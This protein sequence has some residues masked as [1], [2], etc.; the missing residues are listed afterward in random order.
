M[1]P[2]ILQNP[3]SYETRAIRS[4]ILMLDGVAVFSSTL[5]SLSAFRVDLAWG[6]M[7]VGSVEFVRQAMAIAGLREPANMSYPM[8]AMPYLRRQVRETVAGAVSERAFVKPVRTKKFTGFV[9]DPASDP[10]SL[11]EH[12]REQHAAFASAHADEPVWTSE[13]VSFV[14]E[15][16][17]YVSRGR[18]MGS[19]RY[20]PHDTPDAPAPDMA[21]V[22]ECIKAIGNFSS[23][24]IDFGVLDTGE[25]A[26]VEVNDGWAIGLYGGA[27]SNVDYF[28]FLRNRWSDLYRAETS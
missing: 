17:Y 14:S 2:V 5:E 19:A 20:D 18:L 22:L 4:A 23:F 15:W 9:Y 1:R 16:R 7:P 21:L 28:T 13:P 8:Q 12:D 3:S 10:A 24:A 27:M 11:G 6:A 25:T 26:L